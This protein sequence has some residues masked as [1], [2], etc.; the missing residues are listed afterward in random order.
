[1]IATQHIQCN[2]FNNSAFLLVTEEAEIGEIQCTEYPSVTYNEGTYII[3][4]GYLVCYLDYESLLKA[5]GKCKDGTYYIYLV[6]IP[7]DREIYVS[8]TKIACQTLEVLKLFR[9]IK[10]S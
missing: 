2:P 5:L 8:D 9:T 10:L 1:M 7:K 3:H 6:C 4:S